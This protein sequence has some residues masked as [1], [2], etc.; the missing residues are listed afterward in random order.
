M[1]FLLQTTNEEDAFCVL[2]WFFIT[3]EIGGYRINAFPF[4]E[5]G[6]PTGVTEEEIINENL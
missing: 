2:F 6:T 3:V 1:Q 4:E 5:G